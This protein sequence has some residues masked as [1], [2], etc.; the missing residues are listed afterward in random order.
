MTRFRS[1]DPVQARLAQLALRHPPAAAPGIATSPEAIAEAR[2]VW[3][4]VERAD[5]VALLLSQL[6]HLHASA[7]ASG[8]LHLALKCLDRIAAVAKI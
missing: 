3:G 1:G 5:A 6:R 2:E 4:D 7:M 8:D